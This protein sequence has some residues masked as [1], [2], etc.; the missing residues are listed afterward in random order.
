[1]AKTLVKI[2][3]N[4]V[5]ARIMGEWKKALPLLTEEILNDC[6][7]Y[8]KYREGPLLTSSQTATNFKEGIMVW[9]TPY[10]KRQYWEIETAIT[11]KN[12]LARYK[13]VHYARSKHQE[14]WAKKAAKLMGVDT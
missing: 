6:N 5:T 10:A 3:T 7:Q 8:V 1:M 9:R 13:W 11:D 2:D 12:P 4:A 14:E